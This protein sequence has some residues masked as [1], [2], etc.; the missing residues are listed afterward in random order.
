[1]IITPYEIISLNKS[2]LSGF[3]DYVIGNGNE[4]IQG[5]RR[6]SK[7]EVTEFLIKLLEAKDE[8][9]RELRH[10]L[11]L[12]I[13][14]KRLMRFKYEKIDDTYHYNEGKTCLYSSKTIAIYYGVSSEGKL[15]IYNHGCP[16]T[17]QKQYKKGKTTY[18]RLSS[19]KQLKK[20]LRY[21]ETTT[22]PV[23]DLNNLSRTPPKSETD[24]LALLLK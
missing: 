3:Y 16:E 20:S 5:S 21:V 17:V 24:L 23:E 2:K 22:I 6:G 9:V 7:S 19:L 14:K 13:T 15:T 12:A 8:K 11:A 4:P 10:S 18:S 1:M